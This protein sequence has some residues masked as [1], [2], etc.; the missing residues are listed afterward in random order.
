MAWPAS[1]TGP[2][3]RAGERGAS[4]V[5]RNLGRLYSST[6]TPAAPGGPRATRSTMAPCRPPSG[7]VKLPLKE[8]A[9]LVVCAARATSR[10][11]GS[12]S[13]AVTAHD[14]SVP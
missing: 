6:R 2:A 12:S 11:L 10:P 4:S 13:T 8:P 3:S 1:S 7:A 14:G 5:A 9:P